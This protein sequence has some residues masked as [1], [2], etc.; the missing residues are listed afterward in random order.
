MVKSVFNFD[1][2]KIIIMSLNRNYCEQE[3]KQ[4][5]ALLENAKKVLKQ[6]FVGIDTVIEKV[7]DS[8]VTW[9]LFPE[10]QDRPV[11]INL[12]GM[13]G[14]GKT[15]LVVRLANLLDYDKKFFRYDMGICKGKS[16]FF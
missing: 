10:L 14:V 1:G 13:T 3:I 2:Y 9:F 7:I 12:W 16:L 11:V 6:E 8:L 15:A 4:K 5:Q